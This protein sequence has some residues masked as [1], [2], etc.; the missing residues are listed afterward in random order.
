MTFKREF[1]RVK[2]DIATDHMNSILQA[3]YSATL[4]ER[5]PDDLRELV[6]RLK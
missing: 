3:A 4:A 6:E 1:E 5:I 2:R